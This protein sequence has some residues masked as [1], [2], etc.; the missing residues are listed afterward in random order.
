[1]YQFFQ[2]RSD[3]IKVISFTTVNCV[4]TLLVM[5]FTKIPDGV[6]MSEQT[7]MLG[8][9]CQEKTTQWLYLKPCCTRMQEIK[10][11][12]SSIL[13]QAYDAPVVITFT[14]GSGILVTL[15]PEHNEHDV[16]QME[17]V[18]FL[19]DIVVPVFKVCSVVN[20]HRV[21]MYR[22]ITLVVN[23]GMEVNR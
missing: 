7:E 1:M 6:R 19:P 23:L 12:Q 10:V 22:G 21:E 15:H 20:C 16:L 9:S 11:V 17:N 4:Y 13:P 5:C 8:Y 14:C 3:M 2:E 18:K